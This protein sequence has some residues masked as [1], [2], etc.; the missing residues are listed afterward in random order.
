MVCIKCDGF[1]I[2]FN[3]LYKELLSHGIGKVYLITDLKILSAR[4]ICKRSLDDGLRVRHSV[5]ILRTKM[6]IDDIANV[7]AL[8]CLIKSRNHLSC[9]ANELDRLASVI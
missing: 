8:N 3:D 2:F 1:V 6:Y 4:H 7:H 5:C 9:T